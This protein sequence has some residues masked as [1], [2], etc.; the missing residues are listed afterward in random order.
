MTALEHER[1]IELFAEWG[2]R[3]FD[4][5]RWQ[6]HNGNPA[7]YTRA[8]EVMS[9]CKHPWNPSAKLWPLPTNELLLNPMLIQNA[10][11]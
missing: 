1:R 2:H 3:W 10:G 5:S 8:D 7:P 6:A 4:I 9:S 11:Y